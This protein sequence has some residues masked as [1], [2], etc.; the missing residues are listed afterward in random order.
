MRDKIIELTEGYGGS[1]EYEIL[2]GRKLNQA[3]IDKLI[4]E[5]EELKVSELS[6]GELADLQEILSQLAKNL[7][8]TD[9]QIAQAQVKKRAKNGGFTKGQFIKILTAPAGNKWADYYGSDPKR[10]PELN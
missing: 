4:E 2:K 6:A 5:A 1:V 9:T 8:I 3:L 7:K 10:F